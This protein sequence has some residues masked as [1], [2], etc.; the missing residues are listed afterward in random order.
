MTGNSTIILSLVTFWFAHIAGR[1]L[2]NN[3]VYKYK[4]LPL[5]KSLST[6]YSFIFIYIE[7]KD[8]WQCVEAV[9][10][11][12]SPNFG[13]PS[14][15]Q[16]LDSRQQGEVCLNFRFYTMKSKKTGLGI[17]KRQEVSYCRESFAKGVDIMT[18][19]YIHNINYIHGLLSYLRIQ[20]CVY[21][22][23]TM[24]ILL[25]QNG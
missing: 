25:D 12:P 18:C 6:L 21:Y 24:R 5:Y 1:T 11:D 22:A 8:S 9:E 10:S 20:R 17:W 15:I 2:K 4:S 7:S 19:S 23:Y 14:T 13:S 16:S 3:G